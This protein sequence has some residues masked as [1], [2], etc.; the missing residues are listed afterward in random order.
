MKEDGL[1]QT[2][3]DAVRKTVESEK[4]QQILHQIGTKGHE[5]YSAV[6]SYSGYLGEALGKFI[7]HPIQAALYLG[8]VAGSAAVFKG[9]IKENKEYT[10]KPVENEEKKRRTKLAADRKSR[11]C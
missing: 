11:L 9:N 6:G 8:F 3:Y 7:D 10:F 2:Y 5:F 4:A 1:A